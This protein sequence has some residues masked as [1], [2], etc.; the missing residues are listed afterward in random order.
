MCLAYDFSG[1]EKR[2]DE[3]EEDWE[4][5]GEGMVCCY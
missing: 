3:A 1:E 4:E 5:G 2:Q